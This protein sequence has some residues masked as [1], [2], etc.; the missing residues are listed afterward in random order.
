MI[1]AIIILI[2][3]VILVVIHIIEMIDILRTILN[4]VLTTSI[5]FYVGYNVSNIFLSKIFIS[6]GNIM[7]IILFL[8]IIILYMEKII[9]GHKDEE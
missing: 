4:L 3:L 9:I 7:L 8:V 5:L 2:F 1:D 6:L